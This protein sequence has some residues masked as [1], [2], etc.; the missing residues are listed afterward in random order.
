MKKNNLTQQDIEI[1]ETYFTNGFNKTQAYAAHRTHKTSTYNSI[2][3]ASSRFWKRAAVKEYIDNKLNE[4][5][6]ERNELINEL[7]TDLKKRIFEQEIGVNYTYTNRQK[8]IEILLKIS[9]IDK[10]PKYIND[11]KNPFEIGVGAIE[12][13][14]VPPKRELEQPVIIELEG[15][16]NENNE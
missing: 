4:T 14:I 10:A 9:G 3:A 16:E 5:I 15:G 11:I 2:T 7:L 6:G 13:N 12:I 1:I 8:D